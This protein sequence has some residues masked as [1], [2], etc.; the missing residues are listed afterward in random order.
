MLTILPGLI[1]LVARL[2]FGTVRVRVA[3]KAVFD[4]YFT[5]HRDTGHVVAG[6]WHRNAIFF[7]YYFRKL[8][9]AGIM[10]SSSK[11]GDIAAGVARRF[12]YNV[13]RGSSSKGGRT[14][15]E[16][17][18]RYMRESPAQT[19]CG[20]PVDGPRGP[21]RKMKKG[22]LVLARD[23]GAWF[24]PMACSGSRVFTFFKSWDKTILP[25]PFSTMVLTFGTPRKIDPGL[26]DQGLEALRQEVEAEIDDI[27]DRADRISGYADT[28][29]FAAAAT[30]GRPAES[31]KKD[32]TDLT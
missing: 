11:D 31:A 13:V 23:A 19:I 16:N 17:M 29:A 32:K 10:I 18:V 30:E 24:V 5:N 15:L 6:T 14:A 8:K 27:T 7:F 22:M 26:S 2:W 4:R 28:P 9:N 12:G 1:T 21:A 3:D 20:T 25:R